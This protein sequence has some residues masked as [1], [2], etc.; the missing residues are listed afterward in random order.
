MQ[1]Q[2]K[3]AYPGLFGKLVANAILAV[4]RDADQGLYSVLYVATSPEVEKKGWN[5]YYLIDPVHGRIYSI[6]TL[7]LTAMLLG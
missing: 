1:Q 4:G 2:W 6:L 7:L 3:G 5:A